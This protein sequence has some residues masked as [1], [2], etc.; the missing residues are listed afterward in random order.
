MHNQGTAVLDPREAAPAAADAVGQVRDELPITELAVALYASD[1]PAQVRP[2]TD[3]GQIEVWAAQGLARLGAARVWRLAFRSQRAAGR[4]PESRAIWPSSRRQTAAHDMARRYRNARKDQ[5]FGWPVY[6]AVYVE[7]FDIEPGLTWEV[8][9]SRRDRD[10][11]RRWG[12][13]HAITAGSGLGASSGGA[14]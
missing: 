1:M 4:G 13:P 9:V 11:A 8:P 5:G 7:Y 12:S 6:Q 2:D 14:A 10:N 3:A